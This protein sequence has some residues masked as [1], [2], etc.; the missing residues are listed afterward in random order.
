[1]SWSTF[2]QSLESFFSDVGQVFLTNI[3]AAIPVVEQAGLNFLEALADAVVAAI[4]SG[5]IPLP[6]LA[7]EGTPDPVAVSNS[8]RDAAFA[9]I[10]VKLATTNVPPAGITINKSL[11]YLAIEIAV[12]KMKCMGNGGNGGSTGDFSK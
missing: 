12:Q 8:K 3:K 5:A 2:I 4:E 10:Q 7:S 9:A 6:V 1:M 11:T